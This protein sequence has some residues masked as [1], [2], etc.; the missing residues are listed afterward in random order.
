LTLKNL[1]KN[2]G[3]A[4]VLLGL[5]ALAFGMV[6]GA[7]GAIQFLVPDFFSFLPFHK[8]RPLHVS[9]V[10][11][12]IFSGAIGGIYYYLE[13]YLQLKLY[14]VRLATIHFWIFVITGIAVVISYFIGK[15]GGREYWE[16]PPILA[17]PIAVSWILFGINIL[18]TVLSFKDKYPVYLWMW[19]TGIFYF[20][21]T[22]T[23]SYVWI[24]NYFSD[25][26]VR[27]LTMQWKSYGALV[28]SWNML[29][30]G[31]ALFLTEAIGG[32]KKAANSNLAYLLYLLG[33][34]NLMFGWAHHIYIL[35][36]AEWIRMLAYAISMTELLILAKIIWNWKSSL[37]DSAKKLYIASYRFLFAS[38]S[39]ILINLILA[40]LISIPAIN[41]FSHGTHITVAHAM[42]STIGI[43]T[44]IL[45]ASVFYLMNRAYGF[46]GGKLE[47][48]G[49][50]VSN[51]SLVI[52]FSSLILAGVV[53]GVGMIGDGLDF[54]AAMEHAYP[55]LVVFAASG[56]GLAVGFL[57]VIWRVVKLLVLRL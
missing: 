15:F 12:W 44:M 43:N 17:I 51:I 33:L 49:L 19:L 4:F 2:P 8:I 34:V 1:S 23:E 21:F 30:Y 6:F 10:V 55:Y 40:I 45:M 22:F 29:V 9:L 7:I 13:N 36:S 56:V 37:S 48:Y 24:F 25:E 53:K 20:F 18:K 54:H 57:M 35:P 41:L 28:G 3:K 5:L 46:E 32:D 26:P 31:T 27:E 52:F 16:F 47:L 11:A 50:W 42:G 38:D 39:W 14:S